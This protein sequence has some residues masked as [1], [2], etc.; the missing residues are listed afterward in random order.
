[1]KFLNHK[2]LRN[3]EC[4][5]DLIATKKAIGNYLGYEDKCKYCGKTGNELYNESITTDVNVQ[6][7]YYHLKKFEKQIA[8]INKYVKCLTEEEY[9]IKNIIE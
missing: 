1:M 2:I 6:Y 7:L 8:L 5:L 9:I 4:L 3:G